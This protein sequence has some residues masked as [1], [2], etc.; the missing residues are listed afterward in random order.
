V[1]SVTFYIH[2][3]PVIILFDSGA[4]HSFISAKFGAKVGLDFCH[5]KGSYL[6]STPDGKI[7][8]NQIIRHVPIKLGSKPIKT[9][10]ILLALED[11]DFIFGMNWMAL[12]GVTLDI[13]PRA[14]EINS[15]S[16]GANTL[17]LPSQECI[18][19]YT[20]TMEG[21]KP[22]DIPM[23]CKFADIFPNDLPGMPP[24]RDI[25]FIIELQPG[26]APV[27]KKTL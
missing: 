3:K 15:P 26:T 17:F 1:T 23:V 11:M 4:S 20:F 14:M 13:S 12:R 16:H 19:S 8:S 7:A 22:E 2:N 10:L 18:N 27:S 6:I 25:E 5:T 9:D 21:V 24:D